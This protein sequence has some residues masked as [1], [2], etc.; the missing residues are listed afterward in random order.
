MAYA[1]KTTV[2]PEK[3]RLEIERTVT[4]YGATHFLIAQEPER[5]TVMFRYDR[6]QV[7]FLLPLPQQ[8]FSSRAKHDQTI[9]SRWRALLLIIKAKLEASQTEISSFEVEFMPH[10][11]MHGG[12]TIGEQLL[13]ELDQVCLTGKP[14]LLLNP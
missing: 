9:R 14:L 8:D 13:P 4:R 2:S 6:W 10:I 12:R 1:Q 3:T 5:A 7:R 11:V